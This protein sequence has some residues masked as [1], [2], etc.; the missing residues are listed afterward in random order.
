MDHFIERFSHDKASFQA[1][2]EGLEK[3]G[4]VTEDDEP[5][6]SRPIYNNLSE[7][8]YQNIF[9]LHFP[10]EHNRILVRCATFNIGYGFPSFYVAYDYVR[11]NE[12]SILEIKLKRIGILK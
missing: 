11:F 9:K 12:I 6:M 5:S 3:N 7:E 4:Y 8:I 1:L 2:H 10:I